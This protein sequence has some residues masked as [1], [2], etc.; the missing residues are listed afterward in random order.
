M[1]KRKTCALK[2][3]TMCKFASSA[4]MIKGDINT[5]YWECEKYNKVLKENEEKW[6]LRCDE[7]L[8]NSED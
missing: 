4:K 7:C 8:A 2:E 3:K 1:E 5:V 6:L